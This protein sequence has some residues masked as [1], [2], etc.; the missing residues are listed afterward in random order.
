MK[1][2][3]ILFTA[4][5]SLL[6]VSCKQ[7]EEFPQLEITAAN[8]L[9]T[10][11][12]GEG[13]IVYNSSS[14][15]TSV[16]SSV[17]WIVAY[18]RKSDVL[19]DVAEN[20]DMASR[21]A[22]I[23]LKNEEGI[24]AEVT[25]EQKAA[26]FKFEGNDINVGASKSSVEMEYQ[27]LDK[28]VVVIP[29]AAKSWLSA[30]IYS[31]KLVLQVE[32]NPAVSSRNTT[33]NYAIANKTGSFKVTQAAAEPYIKNFE[34]ADIN[35]PKE[36]LEVS[37]PYLTNST[38]TAK[39]SASWITTKIA[40]NNLT[41]T[42]AQNYNDEPREGK[43]DWSV[44]KSDLKGTII[45]KQEK[46]IVI[47]TLELKDS[48]GGKLSE[49]DAAW[50]G[51]EQTITVFTNTPWTVSC[52]ADWVKVNP[53]SSDSKQLEPAN[54]AVKIT[55]DPLSAT[56]DGKARSAELTFTG[57]DVEDGPSV[58]K[59]NQAGF[60]KFTINVTDVTYN[61]VSAEFIPSDDEAR[62]LVGWVAK[63]ENISD[64]EL[65]SANYSE[66]M[67]L[68][69]EYAGM[70]TKDEIFDMLLDMGEAEYDF[71][72]LDELTEYQLYAYEVDSDLN[73]VSPIFRKDFK[74]L[75]N[76]WKYIGKGKYTD[77]FVSGM[78]TVDPKT[79][80]VDI[81]EYKTTPGRYAIDS[82]YGPEMLAGW[83]FNATVAQI[84]AAE[85][86]IWKPVMY[87]INVPSPSQAYCLM[88][89][90]GFYLSEDGWWIG[91]SAVDQGNGRIGV[92]GWGTLANGKI[93]FPE[94]GMRVRLP[95]YNP[96]GLYYGNINN[97]FCL[98][99]PTA[100]PSAAPSSVK[101]AMS[102]YEK[103]VYREAHPIK[104]MTNIKKTPGWSVRAD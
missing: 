98:E 45:V 77:G 12:G 75:E 64:A 47:R 89:E 31:D 83:L 34:P 56:G 96:T 17:D 71:D 5:L 25:I 36:G 14:E 37:Y 91:G 87:E 92:Y 103:A 4:V 1:K 6:L 35:A 2:I 26:K 27:A 101:K 102:R 24:S 58:L 88:Q 23:T 60:T 38:L 43:V 63:A 72:K 13:N 53:A 104:Q 46:G 16:T 95:E 48:E 7:E 55:I 18:A 68:V 19:L 86:Q 85:G 21:T 28:M 32:E 62:Y 20:T 70:F 49:L 8:T 11:A 42:V 57:V 76:P 30:V 22:T 61:T 100:S 78:Y 41:I 3:A 93:T 81:Y 29:D 97:S 67:A 79:V 44:A 40:N 69:A 90:L 65:V 50:N 73:A 99:L 52:T 51:G 66:I 54:Q 39:A 59:I 94:R 33:V 10:Y 74:T 9:F 84:E 80:N 15:V 82:P